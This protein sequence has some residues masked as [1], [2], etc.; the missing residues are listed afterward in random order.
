[1][2]LIPG[3]KLADQI[4]KSIQIK[5]LKS[6]ICNSVLAVILVGNNPSSRLY[7]SIKEKRA[8]EIGLGFKKYLLPA[9]TGQT[10]IINLINQLN[11]DRR[12]TGI[13]VQLPLPKHLN[14]DKIISAIDP[15][16]DADG[17]H[18]KHLKMLGQGQMPPI[19]PATTAA[20][21]ES[22]KYTKVNLTNKSVAIIGKSRIVGLPTYYYLKNYNPNYSLNRQDLKFL[23]T[24][25]NLKSNQPAQKINIYDS[26]TKNLAAKT[27]T[28]DILIVAIGHPGFIT[29]KYVKPNAI[30]IDVGINKIYPVKSPTKGRGAKQFDR[31]KRKIVGDVDFKSVKNK[32]RYLTPVPGGIGPLTVAILLKNTINLAK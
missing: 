1:M 23:A 4:L 16:K 21:I 19:L 10:K 30:V 7:V 14:T 5:N 20:I 31:V 13:I 18:P 26:F 28:A 27:S 12:V 6:T 17:I 9:N 3:R 32:A 8:A 29:A 11:Q 25:K 22:L 24:A 15:A 2:R